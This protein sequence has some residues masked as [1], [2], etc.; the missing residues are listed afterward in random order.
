MWSRS[1]ERYFTT[2]NPAV[3]RGVPV[4]LQYRHSLVAVAACDRTA[5]TVKTEKNITVGI[6][7]HS[8]TIIIIQLDKTSRKLKLGM[9]QY[10]LHA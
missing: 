3:P 5:I 10:R 8:A 9:T 7:C 4:S 1:A 6:T 2:V